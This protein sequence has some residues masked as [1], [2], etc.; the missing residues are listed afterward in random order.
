MPRP[1]RTL[2]G[3]VLACRLYPLSDLTIE[4]RAPKQPTSF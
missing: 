3:E 2:P 1:L 4:G